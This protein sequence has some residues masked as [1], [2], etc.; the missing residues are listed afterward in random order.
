M[1]RREV[2]LVV[3]SSMEEAAVELEDSVLNLAVAA[4][5]LLVEGEAVAARLMASGLLL[6]RG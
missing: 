3:P 1:S 5:R 4:P 6:R 2:V